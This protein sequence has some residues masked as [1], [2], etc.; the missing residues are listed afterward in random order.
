MFWVFL[1]LRKISLVK[2]FLQKKWNGNRVKRSSKMTN[3]FICTL[4]RT[5]DG[6]D[7]NFLS[8]K[9]EDIYWKQ[10]NKRGQ[11]RPKMT[12]FKLE[13]LDDFQLNVWLDLFNE[14]DNENAFLEVKR[15]LLEEIVNKPSFLEI[16]HDVN[17]D[18]TDTGIREALYEKI[19]KLQRIL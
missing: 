13:Y 12:K 9:M 16:L 4:T 10:K 8:S 15:D 11:I 3:E 14:T 6:F 5:N 2:L 1:V 19:S 17:Y 7:I 18:W